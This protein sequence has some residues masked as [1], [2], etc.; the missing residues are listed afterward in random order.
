MHIDKDTGKKKHK[1]LWIVIFWCAF[2]V[3]AIIAQ[4]VLAGMK[5]PVEIATTVII[6]FAGG[7]STAYVGMDKGVKMIKAGYVDGS[8]NAEVEG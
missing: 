8:E 4:L 7:I 1:T 2:A 6:S 5:S 3:L